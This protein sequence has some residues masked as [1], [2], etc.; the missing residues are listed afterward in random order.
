MFSHHIFPQLFYVRLVLYLNFFYLIIFPFSCHFSPELVHYFVCVS[1]WL[2]V[3]WNLGISLAM[4]YYHWTEWNGSHCEHRSF[5]L[6][7]L[8]L[9]IFSSRCASC[10]CGFLSGR[11]FLEFR[12]ELADESSKSMAVKESLNPYITSSCL[13]SPFSCF[14]DSDFCLFWPF[15]FWSSEVVSHWGT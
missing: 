7:L 8:L 1:C 12:D 9:F 2:D 10:S 15:S 3:A 6:S 11:F 13:W 5:L 4:N 14:C